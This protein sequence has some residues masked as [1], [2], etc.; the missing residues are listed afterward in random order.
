MT[1]T[2]VALPESE[3]QAVLSAALR[4]QQGAN[5][6][7]ESWTAEPLN[8]HGARRTVR[9]DLEARLR[10]PTHVQRV[11]WVGKFYDREAEAR[12]VASVLE[13]L[14]GSRCGERGRMSIPRLVWYD[15]Q[16][17]LLLMTYEGGW[18]ITSPLVRYP[19][20]VLPAVGRALAA[21]HAVSVTLDQVTSPAA[22]LLDL[23]RRVA[24]LSSELPERAA[25]LDDTLLQLER[26]APPGPPTPVFV[27]GDF[28]PANLLWRRGSLV[29]LDFDKCSRGDPALDLG[30][31]LTQLRRFALRRP[32]KVRDFSAIR[33]GLLTAYQRRSP[34]DPGLDERVAWYERCVSLRKIHTLTC[35]RTRRPEA[36]AIRRRQAEAIGLME[37]YDGHPA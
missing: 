10:D 26:S 7:L 27:H 13:E 24:E 31:L 1:A 11:Q 33:R 34:P 5:A 22:V 21:V 19:E 28:G 30:T 16:R 32:D 12:R 20:W 9:Y 15:G 14:A 18:S 36:E 6:R 37:A 8:R 17:G 2:P 35:D 3:V 25:A 4:D 23:R 29:V